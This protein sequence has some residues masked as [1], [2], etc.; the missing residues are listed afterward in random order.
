M[1]RAEQ[2][3]VQLLFE[4]RSLEHVPV[5]Q[6]YFAISNDDGSSEDNAFDYCH[7]N[8][9]EKD[10]LGNYLVSMR[11]PSTIYYI[12]G[13]TS[14]VR[15]E[16]G[17]KSSSFDMGEGATFWYQH[18]ARFRSDSSQ[19]VFNVSLFDNAAGGDGDEEPT[20]RAIMVQLNMDTM[21]A[22]LV[23]EHLPSF[24]TTA[25]SQG[26]TQVRPWYGVHV[27]R[28]AYPS[29]S[30]FCRMATFSSV[31]GLF[32][33]SLSTLSEYH[34]VHG[35]CSAV[36]KAASVSAGRASLFTTCSSATIL[37]FS[38]TALSSSIGRER[39]RPSRLWPLTPRPR[40]SPGTAR[41]KLPNGLFSAAETR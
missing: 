30:R 28:T 31:G 29:E 41:Q 9:V 40:L 33:T 2:P 20:A 39:R 4:W 10:S 15:W 5:E 11:G 24:N 18:D 6:T 22:T 35:R 23:W 19:S 1:R 14:E 21:E 27:R 8:S 7:I 38:L 17:G 12:D 32:L 13:Q 34:K 37:P 3:L 25:P 36:P 26:N 16:L